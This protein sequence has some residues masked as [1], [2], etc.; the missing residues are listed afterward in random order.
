VNQIETGS[1]LPFSSTFFF[2]ASLSLIQTSPT[3]L[4]FFFPVLHEA[5][6]SLRDA[7]A[8]RRRRSFAPWF[9]RFHDYFHLSPYATGSLGPYRAEV[10]C[11]FALSHFPFI[12]LRAP[13]IIVKHQ[14]SV[15]L[16]SRTFV[17]EHDASLNPVL[18]KLRDLFCFS[19]SDFSSLCPRG[20]SD[21]S[22]NVRCPQPHPYVLSFFSQFVSFYA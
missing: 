20:K 1:P 11:S 16:S 4:V 17:V 7:T 19:S 9:P 6:V 12:S 8:Y 2:F 21:T 3:L 5:L 22:F 13:S 10:L 14:R 18:A 15:N